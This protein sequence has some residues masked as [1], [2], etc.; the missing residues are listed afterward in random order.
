MQNSY[1]NPVSF[2]PNCPGLL[3]VQSG[4]QPWWLYHHRDRSCPEA[5]VDNICNHWLPVKTKSNHLLLYNKEIDW[6]RFKIQIIDLVQLFCPDSTEF[7]IQILPLWNQ[8][9]FILESRSGRGKG[10]GRELDCLGVQNRL[11]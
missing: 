2:F 1:S 11:I 5:I 4:P 7:E 8:F 3:V 10:M 6:R 9:I